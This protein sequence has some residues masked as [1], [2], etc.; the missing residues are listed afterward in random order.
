M[1]ILLAKQ[2]CL[3]LIQEIFPSS[4][5]SPHNLSIIVVNEHQVLNILYNL[6][7][8][9]GLIPQALFLGE[10]FRL[11]LLNCDDS[12][13]LFLLDCPQ[14]KRTRRNN[15][16]FAEKKRSWNQALKDA[17]LTIL[18]TKHSSLGFSIVFSQDFDQVIPQ[19]CN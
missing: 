17:V 19:L 18:A 12:N 2:L 5:S 10:I 6:D 9:K 13:K 1:I 4:P 7:I 11:F 16:H 3:T 15:S 8:S 14:F